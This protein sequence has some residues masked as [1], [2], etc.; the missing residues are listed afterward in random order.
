MA[1]RGPLSRERLAG[2]RL[3]LSGLPEI[4]ELPEV[5]AG[6]LQGFY[7]GGIRGVAFVQRP[8]VVGLHEVPVLDG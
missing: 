8:V 1:G 4:P 7:V 2:G 6:A 3:R 5:A